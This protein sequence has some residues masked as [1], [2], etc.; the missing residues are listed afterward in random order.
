MIMDRHN[1][2]GVILLESSALLPSETMLLGSPPCI[3]LL[4]L[5]QRL[6]QRQGALD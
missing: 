2:I 1:F 4:G 6:T 3:L 5:E